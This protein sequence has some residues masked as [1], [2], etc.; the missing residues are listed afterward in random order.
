MEREAEVS[1]G[2]R[3]RSPS[4]P[5]SAYNHVVSCYNVRYH[6]TV[7]PPMHHLPNSR[8]YQLTYRY[9][10]LWYSIPLLIS[11]LVPVLNLLVLMVQALIW[12]LYEL[13][14]RVYM[15]N[16]AYVTNPFQHMIFSPQ[17][18][19][20]YSVNNTFLP[21]P[22]SMCPD[23]LNLQHRLRPDGQVTVM[24]YNPAFRRY[25]TGFARARWV[26]LGYLMVTMICCCVSLAFVYPFCGMDVFKTGSS[27]GLM[28]SV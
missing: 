1:A 18:C 8:L 7:P 13:A 15:K 16:A 24:F 22:R 5:I 9:L 17:I 11:A 21:V 26:H 14:Y 2:K 19:T 10:R 4:D 27:L 3:V 28:L 25:Y 6:C 12:L 20:R 23:T